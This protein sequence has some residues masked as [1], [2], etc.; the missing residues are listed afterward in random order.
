M[1]FEKPLFV[2]TFRGVSFHPDKEVGLK[3]EPSLKL[4]CRQAPRAADLQAHSVVTGSENVGM[5]Q[6]KYRGSSSYS[7]DFVPKMKALLM[8]YHCLVL[9]KV[10]SRDVGRSWPK[11]AEALTVLSLR[12][13]GSTGRRLQGGPQDEGIARTFVVINGFI[14]SPRRLINSPSPEDV[15]L[16][17]TKTFPGSSDTKV[18]ILIGQ[19]WRKMRNLLPRTM[20]EI[21]ILWR[22]SCLWWQ[23]FGYKRISPFWWD[24]RDIPW[25]S[26]K[27]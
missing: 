18:R 23:K 12:I 7:T 8:E 21:L 25:N 3:S 27:K 26:F 14:S 5:V 22:V 10:S 1:R 15:S 20:I 19:A 6:V 17:P 16:S 2:I 9:S 11:R 13:L 24:P 4:L